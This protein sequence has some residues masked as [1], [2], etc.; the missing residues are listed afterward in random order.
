MSETPN[1]DMNLVGVHEPECRHE[2]SNSYRLKQSNMTRY[3]APATKTSLS[4]STFHSPLHHFLLSIL[5]SFPPCTFHTPLYP[6]SPHTPLSIL[7]TPRHSQLHSP[8]S[9]LHTPLSSPLSATFLCTLHTAPHHMFY[10]TFLV[11]PVS[12]LRTPLSTHSTHSTHLKPS[13]LPSPHC[14]PLSIPPPLHFLLLATVD[15]TLHSTVCPLWT[16]GS[17]CAQSRRPP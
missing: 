1:E 15:S 11:N 3:A 2:T 13:T 12:I 16:R 7:H 14:T 17:N 6:H 5:R 8:V 10:S 9:I 4:R